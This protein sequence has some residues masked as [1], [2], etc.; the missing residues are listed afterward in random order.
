MVYTL[1]FFP[2]E[3]SLFHNSNIFGSC[4]IHILYTGCAKIEKN[5]SGAKGLNITS[6]RLYMHW[7]TNSSKFTK[8]CCTK[9]QCLSSRM[10]GTFPAA[11]EIQTVCQSACLLK[12]INNKTKNYLLYWLSFYAVQ[13]VRIV[14]A[15]CSGVFTLYSF[16]ILLNKCLLKQFTC[17]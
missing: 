2:S 7:Q 8:K 16:C 15:L 3:C 6:N 10:W 5:N 1:R 14:S 12:K 13:A 11:A 9:W 4:F 17:F